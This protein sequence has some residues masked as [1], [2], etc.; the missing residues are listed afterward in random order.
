MSGGSG[1]GGNGGQ[2]SGGGGS[3]ADAG[4]PGEVFR[5][6]QQ[7]KD[8]DQLKRVLGRNIKEYKKTEAGLS[9]LEK[10]QAALGPTGPGS[11]NHALNNQL[12]RAISKGLDKKQIIKKRL[13][14]IVARR[15]KPT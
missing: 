3:P 7:A 1:G 9:N 12:N 2:T 10:T 5:V 15:G 8:N 4:Q 11:K 13:Q 14:N 6:A